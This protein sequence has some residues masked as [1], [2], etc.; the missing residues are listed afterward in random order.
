MIVQVIFSRLICSGRGY[1]AGEGEG[2]LYVEG[3]PERR[4]I[5]LFRKNRNGI[6]LVATTWS[7][8]D[9]S[10]AFKHL[11]HQ[12]KYMVVGVD[13]LGD[14]DPDAVDFIQPVLPS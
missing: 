12:L 3:L 8:A 10:Y 7:Q 5:L 2:L 1:I 14:Y 6:T 13:H 9:G 4:K 11:N